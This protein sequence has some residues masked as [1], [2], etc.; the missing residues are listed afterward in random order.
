VLR[1]HIRQQTVAFTAEGY[2]IA[3]SQ[4]GERDQDVVSGIEL[5][6]FLQN[7]VRVTPEWRTVQVAPPTLATPQ[8]HGTRQSGHSGGIPF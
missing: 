6:E 2:F 7:L 5:E 4:V 3:L 8:P 1:S